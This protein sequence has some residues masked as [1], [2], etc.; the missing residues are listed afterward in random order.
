M[1]AVDHIPKGV[2][3]VVVSDF[4]AEELVGGAELTLEAILEKCPVE[5]IKLRSE[6]VTRKLI[7]AGKDLHWLLVNY[8]G[9]PKEAITNLLNSGIKYS[10]I[11]CDYKYCCF[12][13]SHLHKLNTKEECNCHETESG[14]STMEVFARSQGIHF[15]SE[16]QMKEYLRLFPQMQEWSDGKLRVQGSTFKDFTLGTLAA[17]QRE[18]KAGVVVKEEWA[19][20]SGGTWIKN[21]EETE[22]YC[23]AK[24][25]PYEVVGGLAPEQFLQKLATY[26]GLVFHPKGFDTAPRITIE[27][28]VMGLEL[29]L[30]SNVQHKD[31]PWF[32]GSPEDCLKE[33]QGRA[34]RFW[35]D[36]SLRGVKDTF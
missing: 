1:R 9:I 35:E 22:E 31:E 27:A 21:L 29:D 25:I 26:R 2:K 15:M 19:V 5:Y 4:F 13:S 12:R 6:K 7:E 14:S 8:T 36:G 11:E 33:L 30:N 20:L 28:K 34:A 18:R 17:L 24:K 32:T 16:G 23:K 10:I 3:L